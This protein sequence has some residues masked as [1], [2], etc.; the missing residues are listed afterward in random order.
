MKK[1]FLSLAVVALLASCGGSNDTVE[2][3]DVEATEGGEHGEH[4]AYKID[5]AASSVKWA[6]SKIV[7]DGH[8]GSIAVQSGEVHVAQGAVVMGEIVIDM[9]SIK[10]EDAGSVEYAEKLVGHL[11]SD[12]FFKVATYPTS[13]IVVKSVENGNV[14]AELTILDV[15]KQITFPAT[16]SV[17]DDKVNVTANFSINRTDWGIVYGSGSFTDSAKDK[18]IKDEIDFQV[19]IVANK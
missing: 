3:Q 10:E 17:A 18:V 7:G 9:N 19:N 5:A 6:G 12:D 1:L 2:A 11:K 15:T 14:T 8:H 4:V 16:I 13:K